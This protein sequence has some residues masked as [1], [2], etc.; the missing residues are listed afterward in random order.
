MFLPALMQGFMVDE[1]IMML[2]SLVMV[3]ALEAMSIARLFAAACGELVRAHTAAVVVAAI[4]VAAVTVL[5]GICVLPRRAREPHPPSF[6]GSATR[7][8]VRC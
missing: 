6:R 5:T 8:R 1:V 4:A 3:A 7:Q 2:V